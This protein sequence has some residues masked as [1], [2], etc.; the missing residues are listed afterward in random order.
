MKSVS[1]DFYVY[2][3]FHLFLKGAHPNHEL[4]TV[5]LRSFC[6]E[7]MA[8]SGSLLMVAGNQ[9]QVIWKSSKHF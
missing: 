7:S 5:T 3:T 4:P 1:F 6:S 9:T 2:L 8:A